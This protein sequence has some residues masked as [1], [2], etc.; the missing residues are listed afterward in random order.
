MGKAK[1]SPAKSEKLLTQPKKTRRGWQKM[2]TDKVD[3]FLILLNRRFSQRAAARIARINENSVTALLKHA[4]V[5]E[6]Q[7]ELLELWTTGVRTAPRMEQAFAEIDHAR[8]ELCEMAVNGEGEKKRGRI[9]SCSVLLQS[10]GLIDAPGPKAYAGANA[11][12]QGGTVEEIYK[13][14]WLRDK[15]AALAKQF[16]AEITPAKQLS[17]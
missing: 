11:V 16:E 9:R 17:P 14:Q 4:W 7:K 6:R 8:A 12:I 10:H 13:S 2:S 5:Q 15:E 1:K 3:E